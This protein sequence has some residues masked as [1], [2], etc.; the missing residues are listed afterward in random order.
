VGVLL[1]QEGFKKNCG[2][3]GFGRLDVL[4]P[5]RAKPFQ[6]LPFYNLASSETSPTVK[7]DIEKVINLIS[8]KK[9]HCLVSY[10]FSLF[11]TS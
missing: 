8:L 5:K 2:W 1:S 11:N 7:L 4:W 9:F 6:F 3:H 10:E